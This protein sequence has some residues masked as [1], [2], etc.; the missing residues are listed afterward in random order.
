MRARLAILFATLA[1]CGDPDP[2]SLADCTPAAPPVALD[3][4]SDTVPAVTNAELQAWLATGSYSTF[5][6]ESAVHGSA[7]PHGGGVRTFLNR[8]VV[9]SLASCATS[10][11][12]GSALVKE[13]FDGDVLEGWAVMVKTQ[14]GP[15]AD[16]WFWYEVFSVEPGA[17]PAYS[18]QA[19]GTCTGCHDGGLDAVRTRWPLR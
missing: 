8:Q 5:L 6:P 16:A 9:G 4:I 1:A 11:P 10:H 3:T 15:G 17:T 2:G 18:G 12:V 14:P 13:L 7:G 19:H